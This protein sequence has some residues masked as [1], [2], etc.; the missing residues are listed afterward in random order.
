[1]PERYPPYQTCR[2]RFQR[3]V[4]EGV[5]S[6]ILEALAHDLKERGGLDLSE[7]FI[8]SALV[9]AKKGEGR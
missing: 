7:C 1:M 4:E 2:R 3:W 9:V 6:R 5:L 8:G